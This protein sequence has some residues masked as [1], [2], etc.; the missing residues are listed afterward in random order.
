MTT[1]KQKKP[2]QTLIPGFV[3]E[4]EII[5]AHYRRIGRK[6]GAVT[7]GKKAA[8]SRRNIMAYNEQ[9]R[10]EKTQHDKED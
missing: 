7:G 10:R 5:R 4:A 8:A 3:T 2:S 6:G 1:E 9:R